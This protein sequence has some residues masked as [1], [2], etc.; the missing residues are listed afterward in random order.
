M[1]KFSIISLNN[2]TIE[3]LQ[4]TYYSNGNSWGVNASIGIGTG[5]SAGSNSAGAGFNVG[6]DN[7]DMAW[8]NQQTTLTGG[9]VNITVGNTTTLTGA[10]ISASGQDKDGTSL[11]SLDTKKLEYNDIQDINNSDSSGFGLSTSV[12]I[13]KTGVSANGSTTITLKDTGEEKEQVTRATI[14][15]GNITING[16]Q[17]TDAQLAGLNRDVDN[18]QEVTRDQ[19]TGALDGSITIDNRLLSEQGRTSIVKDFTNLTA[20]IGQIAE[21]ITNNNIIVQAIS[22]A[23][24]GENSL[25]LVDAVKQYLSLDGKTDK[26]L[27][28]DK[29]NKEINGATNLD[30]EKLKESFKEIA[31][32]YN[33]NGEKLQGLEIANINGNIAGLSYIDKSGQKQTITIDLANVDITDPKAI[34]NIIAHETTNIQSHHTNEANAENRGNMASAIMDMKNYGNENTNNMTTSQWLNQVGSNGVIYANS[35]TIQNGNKTLMGSLINDLNGDG[36][37][38]FKLIVSR[39]G[40]DLSFV[41]NAAAHTSVI[42][43]PDDL[44]EF[45]KEFNKNK[46][47]GELFDDVSTTFADGTQGI[48]MGAYGF[49]GN[50]ISQLNEK[51]DVVAFND[52]VSGNTSSI[53]NPKAV[54]V[55]TQGMADTQLGLQIYQNFLNS[56]K[57][58]SEESRYIQY[59]SIPSTVLSGVAELQGIHFPIINSN[60]YALGLLK[61]VGINNF[62]I[63]DLYYLKGSSY[64]LNNLMSPKLP[65]LPGANSNFNLQYFDNND[66]ND[67]KDEK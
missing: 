63:N 37:T 4:D 22:T 64:N 44:E 12:G 62:N 49:T 11:L 67:K 43:I 7:T 21:N 18:T 53:W 25:G 47:K 15:A 42:Y 28:S 46:S 38:D 50:L 19:I 31:E 35:E 59:P 10:V 30:P 17:A 1:K 20:N 2:L 16:T 51:N 58:M 23:L 60:S 3:S 29:L 52:F 65:V 36:D 57:N 5:K 9:S 6:S 14:G 34:A 39:R 24:D 26:I 48:V 13:S 32:I 27:D 41:L 40:I 61:S 54:D 8:V 55:N 45:K 33:E 66:N 56:K